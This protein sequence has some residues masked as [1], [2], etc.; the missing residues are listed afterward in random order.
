MAMH[1][2]FIRY[3]TKNSIGRV[4]LTEFDRDRDI[5]DLL[6]ECLPESSSDDMPI[7]IL[8]IIVDGERIPK[9]YIA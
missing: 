7:E 5:E 1:R 3:S 6:P 2:Y 9:D 4:C 8:S